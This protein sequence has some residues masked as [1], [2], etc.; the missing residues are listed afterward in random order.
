MKKKKSFL[1][2]LLDWGVNSTLSRLP[3]AGA[4]TVSPQK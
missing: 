3:V 2:P 4:L 1:P